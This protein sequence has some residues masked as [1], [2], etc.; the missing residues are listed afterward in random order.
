MIAKAA[1]SV[2]DILIAARAKIEHADTWT[3][4]SSAKNSHGTATEALAPDATCWCAL[5]AIWASQ[6]AIQNGSAVAIFQKATG[7]SGGEFNDSHT[8][9]E[10][11]AAFDCAIELSRSA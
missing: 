8:H 6:G 5:G 10:V 1:L 3:K 7:G 2:T 4:Y 11:L 9:A